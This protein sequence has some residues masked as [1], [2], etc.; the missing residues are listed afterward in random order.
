MSLINDALKRAKQA[1]VRQ[2]TVPVTE[3]SLEPV[4]AP[5]GGQGQPGWLIPIAVLAGLLLAFWFLVLWWRASQR[6]AAAAQAKSEA[7]NQVAQVMS[8]VEK[9]T[10]SHPVKP[11]SVPTGPSPFLSASAS[12]SSAISFPAPPASAPP[13]P[14]ISHAA[15]PLLASPVQTPE[16][17]AD[18]AASPPAPTESGTNFKLQ[19]IF[20]RSSQASALINGK[21]LFVGDEIDGATLVTIE[22]QAVRLV[23]SGRTNVLKLH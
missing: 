8:A 16:I 14:Q 17:R 4:V 3:P 9:L 23:Q 18:Q 10:K 22:R 15:Q 7:T 2:P 13:I 1:Q 21:T 19:G 6:D 12:P 11:V 5:V 20:Y